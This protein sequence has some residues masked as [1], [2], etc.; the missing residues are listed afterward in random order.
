MPRGY[1]KIAASSPAGLGS[2]IL[3]L[4][5]ALL[6]PADCQ[7]YWIL[8]L[9]GTRATMSASSLASSRK[10]AS[11]PHDPTERGG[12]GRLVILGL[13]GPADL[14]VQQLNVFH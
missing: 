2:R 13:K 7:S 8:G 9:R 1:G 11:T 10:R 14:R 5:F 6:C 3:P 4:V 12:L